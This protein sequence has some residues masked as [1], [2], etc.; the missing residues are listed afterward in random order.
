MPRSTRAI[1]TLFCVSFLLI[2]AKPAFAGPFR[3]FLV[4]DPILED[5]RF[6]SREAGDSLLSLTPP[7]SADE[8][9]NALSSIDYGELTR[10]GTHAYDRIVAALS[11][12]PRLIDGA[13][14]ISAHPALAVEGR[15]RSDA[16]IDWTRAE[17]RSASAATVPLEFF[18][19]DAV[20]AAGDLEIRLDPIYYEETGDSF[21]SN[22]PTVS[23]SLDLNIPL[24]AYLVAGG[25][26]WN[27]Q[28]GRNKISF[29][30]AFT[31][32]LSFSSNPDYY[33]FARL[34]LFSPNFKY[35]LFVA[36]V[37]LDAR[38]L[39]SVPDG[40]LAETNQRY[41]YYHR[42][43]M[44]LYQKLSLS[45]GEAA[46]VGDSPLELRFLNPLAMYHGYFS[47]LDYPSW[48]EDGEMVGSFMTF[49][50]DW[51]ALP[52]LAIYGQAVMTQF[53]TEYEK[54]RWPEDG[55][56]NGWGFL[57]GAEWVVSADET[58]IVLGAEA[59][60]ADPFLY[61]LSSPF[62]SY[63]W[64][65]R[66][67]ALTKKEPRYGWIGHPEGRDFILVALRCRVDPRLPPTAG[68]LEL[69]FRASAKWQGERGLA[70]DWE[71]GSE[72]STL[73]APSGIA[74]RRAEV[75]AT[76]RWRPSTWFDFEFYAAAIRIDDAGH[77][78]GLEAFGAE[79]AIMA[80]FS[81]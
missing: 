61:I 3:A 26:W 79:A 71:S 57:G 39:T 64:M 72:V 16:D 67:S 50:V 18:F 52:S 63:I 11:I 12:R 30:N 41:L 66:L 13:F 78:R 10:A 48:G 15:V 4:D 19:A 25:S 9:E 76:A 45:I 54:K 75:S 1:P 21:S 80:R 27:A 46:L 68:D 51:A 34:S 58:G 56:P 81:W 28:I 14:G 22:I 49:D 36:Q 77:I 7:L 8:I 55:R 6:L 60:Y 62:S 29:G 74:E 17:Y 70:W 20:Y 23:D 53:Q 40:Q 42:W 73:T 5:L 38:G 32:N 33:E 35:S 47:W 37:P 69:D 65:R 44:R 31:G 2:F 43:D 24:R 59:V